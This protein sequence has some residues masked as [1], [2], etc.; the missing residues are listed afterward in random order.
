MNMTD[1]FVKK[2]RYFVIS[3]IPFSQSYIKYSFYY[4]GKQSLET[5]QY[6]Y[7]NTLQWMNLIIMNIQYYSAIYNDHIY[8]LYC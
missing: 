8:M 7:E 4:T 6:V 5:F 1:Y 3:N 2:S